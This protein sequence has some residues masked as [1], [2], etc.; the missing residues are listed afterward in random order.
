LFL[1]ELQA[2]FDLTHNPA[3][4]FQSWGPWGFRESDPEIRHRHVAHGARRII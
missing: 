2:A 3:A 1:N 4:G